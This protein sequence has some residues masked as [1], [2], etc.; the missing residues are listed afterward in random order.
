MTIQK[1]LTIILTAHNCGE[2]LEATLASVDA[3]VGQN[4]DEI[5]FI[6]INDSSIDNTHEILKKYQGKFPCTQVYQ[7]NYKNIGKVRN[8]GISKSHGQYITM[9]DGDDCILPGSYAE[10]MAFLKAKKPDL[11]LTQLNEVYDDKKKPQQWPGLNAQRLTQPDTIKKFL[12]HKQIKAHFIGQFIKREGLIAHPFP[13]FHCYEDAYL[14]PTILKNSNVI[15]FSTVSNYLYYKRKNSLSTQIDQEKVSL[16][17][18]ATQAM[19]KEFGSA[20]Q[21]LTACH[22]LNIFL[23]YRKNISNPTIYQEVVKRLCQINKFRFLFNSSIRLSFK[24]KYLTAL[25]MIK[26]EQMINVQ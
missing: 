1:L 23:R 2:F 21:D 13:E 8:F 25:R 24:R 18:L 10:I 4:H 22:W 20:Y 26:K 9:I 5:E 14:F 3:A 7:V 11:L 17:V 12:Q 15:Y 6:F 19:D 16:L